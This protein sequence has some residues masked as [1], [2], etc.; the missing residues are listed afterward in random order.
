MVL[1]FIKLFS[2]LTHLVPD[3]L[4]NLPLAITDVL[5]M[6]PKCFLFGIFKLMVVAVLA[7][8]LSLLVPL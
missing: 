6:L 4:L 8:L 2:L 7:G 5:L 1:L 3:L